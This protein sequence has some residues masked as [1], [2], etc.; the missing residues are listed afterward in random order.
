MLPRQ[1]GGSLANIFS[2][3][4][5]FRPRRGEHL[6]SGGLGEVL[7]QSRGSIETIFSSI[8]DFRPRSEQPRDFPG[9]QPPRSPSAA[10]PK[11]TDSTDNTIQSDDDIEEDGHDTPSGDD[12]I[13]MST[14]FLH[15]A[16]VEGSFWCYDAVQARIYKPRASDS[17][18][19]Q[20]RIPTGESDLA[21]VEF[22]S[23]VENSLQPL[24]SGYDDDDDDFRNEGSILT[25]C[26]D[27]FDEVKNSY[28]QFNEE[29]DDSTSGTYIDWSL[30]TQ[31]T[32]KLAFSR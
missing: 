9:M 6:N 19:E 16:L 15:R 3:L 1:A 5:N 18:L 32:I 14:G 30:W 22:S 17:K 26:L 4:Q 7:R 2:S 20:H 23:I 27:T 24:W 28:P 21:L 10:A 29:H 12:A 31:P 8:R 11:H 13:N 25:E